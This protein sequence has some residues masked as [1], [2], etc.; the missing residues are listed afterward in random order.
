MN[1]DTTFDVMEGFV[2]DCC[3]AKLKIEAPNNDEHTAT[4]LFHCSKCD[5]VC[6]FEPVEDGDE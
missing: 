3:Q 5:K 6:S 1:K 4:G 2:S